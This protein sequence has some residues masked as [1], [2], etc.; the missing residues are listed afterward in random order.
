MS[1]QQQAI[2]QSFSFR[3]AAA[4]SLYTARF[5]AEHDPERAELKE[6]IASLFLSKTVY[7]SLIAV[8]VAV[9]LAKDSCWEYG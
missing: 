5:L 3:L 9:A 8:V 4:R 2:H 1:R 6:R 7:A